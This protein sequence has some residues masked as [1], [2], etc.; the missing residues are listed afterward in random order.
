MCKKQTS[1][2]HSSTGSEI[3]SL[4]AQLRMD[5]LLALDFWDVV[6]KVCV[7]QTAPKHQQTQH[8]KTDE[9]QE[10]VR[11]MT[12][13]NPNNRETEMLSNGRMW[14]TL[15]QTHI[16]PKASLRLYIFEDNEAVMAWGSPRQVINRRRRARKGPELACVRAPSLSGGTRRE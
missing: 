2:S 15:P 1:V 16:P 7:R 11:E 6:M 3:I 9:R 4:D 14:T 12:N 5:G 8:L 13:P 10:T